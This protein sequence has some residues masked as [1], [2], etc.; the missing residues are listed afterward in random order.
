MIASVLRR[1]VETKQR[2]YAPVILRGR[3]VDLNVISSGKPRRNNSPRETANNPIGQ[4]LAGPNRAWFTYSRNSRNRR[5]AKAIDN[6]SV[7]RLLGQL[8]D[9]DTD[10]RRV[11]VV[12]V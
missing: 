5:N 4:V 8:E 12:C 2:L 9:G 1:Y 7:G 11:K 6:R 10:C 3:Q